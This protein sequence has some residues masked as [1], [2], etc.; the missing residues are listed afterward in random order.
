MTLCAGATVQQTIEAALAMLLDRLTSEGTPAR[1]ALFVG[2]DT[3]A[4]ALA[5]AARACP[6]PPEAWDSVDWPLEASGEPLGFLRF[7]VADVAHDGA[8][9]TTVAEITA[10]LARDEPRVSSLLIG[11]AHLA[12]LA[13]YF[14]AAGNARRRAR[15]AG[16]SR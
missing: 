9:T 5:E 15:A 8:G 7:A 6:L 11:L 13:D 3:Q 1:A 12:A 2:R 10:T 16:E 4:A 14:R